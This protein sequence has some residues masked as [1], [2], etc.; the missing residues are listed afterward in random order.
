M[1]PPQRYFFLYTEPVQRL[2][3]VF[4]GCCIRKHCRST[5][6]AAEQPQLTQRALNY[7]AQQGCAIVF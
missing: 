5:R 1:Y 7:F 2:R 4:F 3:A 6:G